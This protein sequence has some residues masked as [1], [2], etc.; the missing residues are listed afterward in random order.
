MLT[1]RL[2][3]S[4]QL[5]HLHLLISVLLA[6]T[7]PSIPNTNISILVEQALIILNGA[8]LLIRLVFPVLKSTSV[9]RELIGLFTVLVD[10]I[11]QLQDNSKKHLKHQQVILTLQPVMLG[12]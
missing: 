2:G 1:V 12:P 4:V 5:D 8:R 10:I 9:L 11:A 7:A 3:I 6:I